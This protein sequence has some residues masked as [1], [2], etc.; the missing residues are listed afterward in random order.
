ML[1]IILRLIISG[2]LMVGTA[3]LPALT[4]AYAAPQVAKF[5]SMSKPT[6]SCPPQRAT[7]I[8]TC[9]G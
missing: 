5:L 9:V 4:S 6:R 3:H 2:V 8:R 7:V 1:D